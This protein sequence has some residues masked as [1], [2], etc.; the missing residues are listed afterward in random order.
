L[1][2]TAPA[3]STTGVASSDITSTSLPA[4]TITMMAATGATGS[5]ARTSPPP[6]PVLPTT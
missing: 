5:S 3:T 6:S 2:A 1:A 4:P